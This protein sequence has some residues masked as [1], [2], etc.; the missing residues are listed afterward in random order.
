MQTLLVITAQAS[1]AASIEAAI[2]PGAFRVIAKDDPAAAA[3]LLG[4]GAVDAIIL[5]L[6]NSDGVATRGIAEIRSLDPDCP[7]IAF[8]GPG[9]GP[10]EEEAYLLGAAHVLE[11]PVRARLLQYLLG[12]TLAG[13]SASGEAE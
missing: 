12:R 4:R 8:C 3:S 2:N 1:F 6:E 11:K 7:L 13:G 5:D 10:W 9:P